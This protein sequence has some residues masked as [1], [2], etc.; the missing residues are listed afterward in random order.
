MQQLRYHQDDAER[1][2]NRLEVQLPKPRNATHLDRKGVDNR[3]ANVLVLRR[4]SGSRTG[5]RNAMP[6]R[7]NVKI[8][9]H[10]VGCFFVVYCKPKFRPP[11]ADIEPRARGGGVE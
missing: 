8:S 6:S 7:L 3:P 4:R 9:L 10:G 2:A 11:A 5:C 1:W